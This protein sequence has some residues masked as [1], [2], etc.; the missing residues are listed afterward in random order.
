M[1]PADE[2]ALIGEAQ[3]GSTAAF[4]ELVRRY[5]RSVLRLALRLLRSE[6]EARDI[7]QEAF[8]RI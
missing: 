7:Y 4:E 1:P 6:D 5:D 2:S 3:R 8:L